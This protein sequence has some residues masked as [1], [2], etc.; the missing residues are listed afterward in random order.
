MVRRFDRGPAYLLT[1]LPLICH[2][3]ANYLGNVDVEN[4]HRGK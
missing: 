4:Y 3:F 2:L 1:H